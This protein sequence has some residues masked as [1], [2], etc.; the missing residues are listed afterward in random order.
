M[1]TSEPVPGRS[2]R[3]VFCL[4]GYS[5]AGVNI[6]KIQNSDYSTLKLNLRY[7]FNDE[8]PDTTKI[9][10]DA[11]YSYGLVIDNIYA[12]GASAIATFTNDE[13][14]SDSDIITE[15]NGNLNAGTTEDYHNNSE[16]NNVN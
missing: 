2:C 5:C 16:Y 11:Q 3:G 7:K 9:S 14:H 8:Q 15:K 12:P 10:G 6:Y 13:P 1:I 4:R